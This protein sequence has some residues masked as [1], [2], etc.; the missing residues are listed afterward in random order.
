MNFKLIRGDDHTFALEFKQDGVPKNITGW[1]VFLTVKK[2]IDDLDANAVISKTV[3]SH[4]DP[5][6]GKT[7]I[8]IADTETDPLC[9]IYYYDIQYKDLAGIIKT[10]MLGTLNF[11]KD[12]TRRIA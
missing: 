8:S 6:N 2:N 10:V 5:T 4:T 3:T 1:T 11:Y 7:E 9:G 12:V